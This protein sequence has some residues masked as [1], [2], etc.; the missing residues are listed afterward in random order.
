MN[1]TFVC[2]SYLPRLSTPLDVS[3][4]H[5]PPWPVTGIAL[6]FTNIDEECYPETKT[7]KLALFITS[8]LIKGQ[9]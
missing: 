8:V 9:I 2:S 4:P 3:Q 1:P 7:E 5:G 6:P